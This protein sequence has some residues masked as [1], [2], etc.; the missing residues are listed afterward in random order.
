MAT[1]QTRRSPVEVSRVI[2]RADDPPAEAGFVL[3]YAREVD[4]VVRMTARFSNGSVSIIL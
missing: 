1:T 2:I 4:G 3:V